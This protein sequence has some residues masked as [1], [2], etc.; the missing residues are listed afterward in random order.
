[1]KLLCIFGL[2]RYQYVTYVTFETVP[3]EGLE[4]LHA[5]NTHYTQCKR[6]GKKQC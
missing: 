3:G 6:C 2:H 4:S 1:M 5:V